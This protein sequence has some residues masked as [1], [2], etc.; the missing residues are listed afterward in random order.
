MT[1]FNIVWASAVFHQIACQLG[2]LEYQLLHNETL[3][4]PTAVDYLVITMQ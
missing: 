1:L 2:E 4:N 3:W